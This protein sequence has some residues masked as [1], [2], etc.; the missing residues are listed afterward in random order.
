MVRKMLKA[1][2]RVTADKT[3]F[4]IDIKILTIIV[5]HFIYRYNPPEYNINSYATSSFLNL[6]NDLLCPFTQTGMSGWLTSFLISLF[7]KS[8]TF[9]K[10]PLLLL[11]NLCTVPVF[12]DTCTV[13]KM[14]LQ[15]FYIHHNALGLN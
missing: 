14:I 13:S 15:H 11:D 1:F 8:S 10:L 9:I 3:H 7:H 4:A 2:I 12:S 5:Y 6:L